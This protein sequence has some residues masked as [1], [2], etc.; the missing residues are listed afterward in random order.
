MFGIPLEVAEAGEQVDRE[1]H[2]AGTDRK[3]AHVCADQ[4]S[5]G[6]LASQSQQCRGEIEAKTTGPRGYEGTGMAASP[7]RHV[8]HSPPRLKW[9][10]AANE[11]HRSLRV[12]LIPVGIEAE[13][14]L[15]EPFLEPFGHRKRSRV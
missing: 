6:H 5:I 1:V 13:V 2:G 11:G 12:G 7:A 8:Q 4:W 10:R 9:Q 14:V 3:L 15:A